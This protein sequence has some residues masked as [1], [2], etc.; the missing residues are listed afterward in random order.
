MRKLACLIHLCCSLLVCGLTYAAIDNGEEKAIVCAACHGPAGVSTNPEW[1]NLAGQHRAYLVKQINDMKQAKLRASPIMAPMI[2]NL[3]SKDI[4][5]LASYYSQQPIPAGVTPKAYLSKGERLYRGGD[6][7]K[8][9][10][11]CIACHGPRGTG[12]AQAGFPVVSG[13]HAA[14]TVLQLQQFKT[15][16]RKNDLNSIMRD[17][18]QRMS[19]DDMLAVANY[20][21]GLH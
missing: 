11:A 14:Y 15:G 16:Q 9:I 20:I 19:S 17:I 13:Q 3:T 1:P 2:E 12:N 21:A 4:Q 18:S 8:H 6:F 7:D 10:T 5:D